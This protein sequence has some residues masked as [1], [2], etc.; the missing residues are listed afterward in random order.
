MILSF[1]DVRELKREVAE[2]FSAPVQERDDYRAL[3]RFNEADA[4]MRQAVAE[5]GD[6]YSKD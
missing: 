1:D 6:L 3:P 2:K 5:D 4:R